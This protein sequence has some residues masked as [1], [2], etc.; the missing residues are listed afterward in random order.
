MKEENTEKKYIK[1]DNS[2]CR[3]VLSFVI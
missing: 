1:G 3:E 2:L